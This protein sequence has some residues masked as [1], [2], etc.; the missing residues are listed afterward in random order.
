MPITIQQRDLLK[1]LQTNHLHFSSSWNDAAGV[2]SFARS[3]DLAQQLPGAVGRVADPDATLREFL[4]KYELLFGPT[5]L[6]PSLHLVR[7]KQDQVG[8]THYEYQ[9]TW[10]PDGGEK[11]RQGSVEVYGSKLAAHFAP[12]N[13]LVEVQSS[14]HSAIAPANEPKVPAASLGA[15]VLASIERLKGFAEL[16]D[17][18]KKHEERLF[19]LMQ[20]PRLVI[21]PWKGKHIYAW[22][23]YGYGVL[24]KEEQDPRSASQDAIAFGQMF[25]DAESGELFLFAPTRKG[26]EMPTTG[27]GLGCTPLGGPFTNRALQVVRVDAGSTYLLKNTTKGR[28][29]VTFDAN[30]NS[31][32]VYPH[33]PSFIDSGTIPTSSDTDGDDT[34]NRTAANTTDAERTASQQPEVDEHSTVAELYDWYAAVGGRVGWDD[35][36]YAAPLVPNQHI[37]VVAHT[38][39]PFSGTSRSVNAFFDQ[40]LV[41]GHWVS[42]LAFFDGDPTGATDPAL[43]FDYLA[44]SR[45]IVAHEYQHA[46]TDFSFIDGAGN[47]GLTYSDW[48]A[49]VHEGTSDVFGGLFSGE[50]WMGT[51]VSPTGQIFRNLAFPRDTAAADPSKFDHWD[52]RNTITGSGA[53]YFRGDILAHAAYLMAQGGVHQRSARTP[54]LIPVRGLGQETLGAVTVYRA[55]RIWYRAIAHYLS[56]I[57]AATGLPANDEGVFRTIRDACVSAAIDLF[58]VNSTEHKTTVLAWYAVGLQPAGTPYGADVTFV[59]WGADW[60][61]SRPFIGVSSPD[62]SSRD[63]FINNGGASEWNAKINVIDGGTPT[64]FENKVY[65]R[66]RNVGDQPASNVQIQFEYAKVGSSG[67]AW[68]PMTDKDGNI[69]TLNLGTLAAGQSSFDDSA[70]DTPPGTAMV[71]WWIPPLEPGETVDHFCMRA[72]VFSISDVDAFNN[73][74]QSN[75]AYVPYV[76]GSGFRAGFFVGNERREPLPLELVVGHTLPEEWR[77]RFVEPVQGIVLKPG[78]RRR[79]HA[80][81]DAPAS[82]GTRLEPPFDGRI[83]GRISG[84]HGGS[85]VGTLFRSRFNGGQ[86]TG[87]VSLNLHD[88]A[89]LSGQFSGALHVD[90]ARFEGRAAGVLQRPHGKGT[91]KVEVQIEGWLRPDRV[92]NVGQYHGKQ[93]LGGVSFQ[94]QV[95]LPAGTGFEALP[96]TDTLVTPKHTPGR[97]RVENANELLDC[98]DLS[99]KKVRSI[100]VRSVIVELKLADD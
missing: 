28:D 51:D 49:A 4:D 56:N 65:C 22:A 97:I 80:V 61:M 57:G 67:G 64:Q 71:K 66:V 95:P 60:W 5:Q 10:A 52:D 84:E 23:T 19:P 24:T 46:I 2:L 21:Y 96:P 12:G 54:A 26:A 8:F 16:R 31:A 41:S 25:F 68:L 53:R 9:Q 72:R 3:E 78:E 1:Q 39:D 27:T 81:I 47:P 93:P 73:E 45:A 69:Q 11:N 13:K 83:R 88:G 87:Q 43:V 90:T 89:H 70:Q 7:K 20:A 34:W 48:L 33:I 77:F 62:W 35:N 18:M 6:L 74:V 86:L 85:Y 14:C 98:L 100:A 76:P 38:Y 79:I 92:V 44:G 55:A 40:E 82:E 36:Q 15:K 99:D 91:S 42:H 50:W 17:R 59:T 63:L 29:I 58:G 37:N 32:W 30:A 75:V 94:V